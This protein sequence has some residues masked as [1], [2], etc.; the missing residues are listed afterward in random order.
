MVRNTDVITLL[1]STL[2]IRFFNDSNALMKFLI[3]LVACLNPAPNTEDKIL[4]PL[5][6][7][8]HISLNVLFVAL[9]TFLNTFVKLIV[10][11]IWSFTCEELGIGFKD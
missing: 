8:F 11:V 7:H 3:P 4:P 10:F 9:R 6:P 2:P 5:F 1:K